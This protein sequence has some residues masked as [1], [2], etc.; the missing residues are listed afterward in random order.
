[1]VQAILIP[2]DEDQPFYK[3][4]VNNL[5]D[6]QAAV[7]GLIEVIDLGPL[8]A[9]F[10]VNEEGKIEKKPIN[11]RATLIWWLLFPS[12]RHMDVIV[13][14]ALMVG[15]P[16]NNG[17]STDVPEDLVKLLFETKSYKAEFQT[18]D[19]ANRFNGNLRRFE[20]YF[21]AVNY[22]LGKAESWSAV[23]RVRVVAAED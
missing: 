21:E 8:G 4:E 18:Y 16:D 5:K 11:R 13:G 22:A 3:L 12:A 1:M 23:Q 10:F 15:Q 6:M 19:D 14:E 7:G 20:G 9:T 17:D 2:Q